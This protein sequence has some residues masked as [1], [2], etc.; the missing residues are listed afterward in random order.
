MGL[1]SYIVACE[2][3]RVTSKSSLR[4]DGCKAQ[5]SVLKARES[6]NNYSLYSG[7]LTIQHVTINCTV[8]CQKKVQPPRQAFLW[9]NNGKY[10]IEHDTFHLTDLSSLSFHR[11]QLLV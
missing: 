11:K 9:H 8:L 3:D 1:D 10:G 2:G 7:G 6:V 4:L 5:R